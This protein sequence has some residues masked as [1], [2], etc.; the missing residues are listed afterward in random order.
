MIRLE[1][2]VSVTSGHAFRGSLANLAAGGMKLIRPSDLDNFDETKIG[3]YA[4]NAPVLSLNDGDILLSNRGKFRAAIMTH[5]GE[6]VLPASIFIL[7]VRDERILPQYLVAFFNSRRG[8]ATLAS[9]ATQS[10][11]PALTKS[12]LGEM[13]IAVPPI[14]RQRQIAG[15][16]ADVATQRKL[17]LEQIAANEEIMHQVMEKEK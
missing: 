16:A 5:P 14:E 6:Y 8:Q 15:M 2:L 12:V 11:I 4:L 1:E 9:A 17:A 13:Q 3:G 7:K 10:Y